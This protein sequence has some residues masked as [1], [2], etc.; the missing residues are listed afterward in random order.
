M[1]KDSALYSFYYF[2]YSDSIAVK[3]IIAQLAFPCFWR[4]NSSKRMVHHL[5]IALR[6]SLTLVT[7]TCFWS[8]SPRYSYNISKKLILQMQQAVS[9]SRSRTAKFPLNFFLLQVLCISGKACLKTNRNDPLPRYQVP[10]SSSSDFFL[11]LRTSQ[12]NYN[13]ILAKFFF[14]VSVY[15]Q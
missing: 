8:P 6:I 14:L 2:P 13:N 3:A 15:T 4:L 7:T 11:T 9:N 10:T 5:S 1:F 12:L